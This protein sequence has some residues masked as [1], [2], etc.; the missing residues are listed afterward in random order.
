MTPLCCNSS[1]LSLIALET[2]RLLVQILFFFYI[3]INRR[4]KHKCLIVVQ[5]FLSV[6]S[7]NS[8][9]NFRVTFFEFTVFLMRLSHEKYSDLFWSA[10]SRIRTEQLRIQTLF[11][12]CPCFQFSWQ[13]IYS[14]SDVNV[15]SRRNIVKNWHIIWI[16]S[17]W[18][19]ACSKSIEIL[20]KLWNMFRVSNKCNKTMS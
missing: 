2:M 8:I 17:Q 20:K 9:F 19:F 5:R 16:A 3:V 10:S 14:T 12:Q 18:T 13:L 1:S 15:I 11:T 7:L 6:L 4:K